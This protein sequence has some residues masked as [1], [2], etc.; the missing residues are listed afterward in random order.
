MEKRPEKHFQGDKGEK[1]IFKIETTENHFQ[2]DKRQKI[3]FKTTS[4]KKNIFK[5]SSAKKSEQQT[6]RKSFLKQHVLEKL[7][8]QM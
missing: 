7:S 3:I 6:S 2:N 5:R 8:L 1:I 4:V